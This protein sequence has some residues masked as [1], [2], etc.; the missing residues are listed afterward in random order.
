MEN[1]Q[2]DYKKYKWFFTS[3]GKLVVGGKSAEQNDFLLDYIKKTGKELLIM[4]TEEPG[5]PFSFILSDLS[6]ITP[7]DLKEC[8]IFTG[9]FSRAWREG[10]K[11]AFVHI[12]NSSQIY[13]NEKMKTGT[14]G[15]VGKVKRMEVSLSLV[16]VK[17]KS[18]LRA[19]PE[20]SVKKS[21]ILL[22]IAP[23]RINKIDMLPKIQ[24]NLS[25]DISQEELL[26]ALPSGGLRI[27]QK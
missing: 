26:S 20:I 8:A 15:V 19:V 23:G 6:K 22:C 21:E 2:K 9:C 3:T 4:H 14:W 25:E 17:Q 10:K 18:V 5:S 11:K 27:L 13:K 12:F 16:L 1:L 24:L 7:S